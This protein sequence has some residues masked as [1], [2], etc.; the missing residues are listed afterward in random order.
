MERLV[1]SQ[2]RDE[3]VEALLFCCTSTAMM[4]SKCWF[5][6]TGACR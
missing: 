6:K 2:S 3:V 5:R 4:M 1:T